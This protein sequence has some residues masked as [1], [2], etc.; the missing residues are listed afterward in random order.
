MNKRFATIVLFLIV[1]TLGCTLSNRLDISEKYA[2]NVNAIVKVIN[3][4]KGFGAGFILNKEKGYIVTAAHML[5]KN[6]STA[7]VFLRTD[8][9]LKAVIAAI[10]HKNDILILKVNPEKLKGLKIRQVKLATKQI[11]GER[12]FGIGH[13]EEIIGVVSSGIVSSG[14]IHVSNPKSVLPRTYFLSDIHIYFGN[15]GGPVFNYKN[16]VVGIVVRF[17]HTYSCIVPSQSIERLVN[18]ISK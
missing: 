13:P 11:V 12:V 1:M 17:W 4:D 5:K 14:F 2:E 7:F 18:N 15:S 8:K 10:D 9:K 3:P 16:E 6:H